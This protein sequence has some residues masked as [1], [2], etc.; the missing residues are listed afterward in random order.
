MKR[1]DDVIICVI[2]VIFLPGKYNILRENRCHKE[3]NLA[4]IFVGKMAP[5]C[6]WYLIRMDCH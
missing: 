5:E 2:F 6:F 3:I 4:V 1:L